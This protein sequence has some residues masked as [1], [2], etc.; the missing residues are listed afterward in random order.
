MA[1]LYWS[2]PATYALILS[3]Y[4]TENCLRHPGSS[5]FSHPYNYCM[6]S[7]SPTPEPLLGQIVLSAYCLVFAVP[8]LLAVPLIYGVIFSRRRYLEARMATFP[9][10]WRERHAVS[11]KAH[12]LSFL[13]TMPGILIRQTLFVAPDK[14]NVANTYLSL[15]IPSFSFFVIPCVENML[16]EKLRASLFCFDF[17]NVI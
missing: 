11:A 3:L 7:P 8:V 17:L 15:L 13:C 6:K 12:F 4:T 2:N 5:R 1:F 14:F 16:S 9:S 10:H